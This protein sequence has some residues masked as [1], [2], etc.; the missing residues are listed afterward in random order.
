MAKDWYCRIAGEELGPFSAS[1]LRALAAEGRLSPGDPLRQGDS[2]VWVPAASV[3]GLFEGDARTGFP[4]ATIGRNASVEGRTRPLLKAAPL[5]DGSGEPGDLSS[6]SRLLDQDDAGIDLASPPPEL[7][8][9]TP[10]RLKGWRST[11]LEFLADEPPPMARRAEHE[12]PR[13]AEVATLGKTAG[14]R[15]SARG[16]HGEDGDPAAPI[17]RWMLPVLVAILIV[18][19]AVW[20]V[21][22]HGERSRAGD[23]GAEGA[24]SVPGPA[25]PQANTAGKAAEPR[26]PRPARL[27]QPA[28]TAS[29]KPATGEHGSGFRPPPPDPSGKKDSTKSAPLPSSPDEPPPKQGTPPPKNDKPPLPARTGQLKT[30]FGT[31]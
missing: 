24:A 29:G 16:R 1:Q 10:Q 26:V 6:L 28:E 23:R 14:V 19:S 3:K 8:P 17:R 15:V 12:A 22:Q 30:E 4:A 21:L 2:G 11:G 20:M 13:R 31:E 5:E 7:P 18:L 9:A 27:S 25:A